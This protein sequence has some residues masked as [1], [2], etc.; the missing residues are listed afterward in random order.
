MSQRPALPKGTRDFNAEQVVKRQ[1][2]RDTIVE[3]YE[4]F[5]FE[6]LETPSMELLST[7]TGKYGVEGDQLLFRILKSGDFL[8]GVK[9]EALAKK[10]ARAM[11]PE[12][13][14]KGLRY[15]LTVPFARY[16]VMNQHNLTMPFRRYQVQPVW[17]ADRPQKGR[18]Q[19]F[20][21]CDAD[22]IGS[23]TMLSE[24]EFIQIYDEVFRRLGIKARL[25]INNRKILNGVA[26]LIKA[27]E[28]FGPICVAMDKLDKIGPEG[29]REELLRFGL[30]ASQVDQLQDLL[31]IEGSNMMR[32]NELADRFAGG[33]IDPKGIE[34]MW[35]I[36][37][38]ASQLGIEHLDIR[39]D[40]SLARGLS[41]Y[42]GTIFE[43]VAT[44]HQIG[45]LSGGGRYDDLTGIFGLPD[46]SG[47]GI[48]FGIERLYDV[49]EEQG[50]PVDFSRRGTRVVF[51][52]FEASCVPRAMECLR[53]VRAAGINAELH[54]DL[55]AK[56]G[57]KIKYADKKGIPFAAIIGPDELESGLVKLKVLSSGDQ[58]SL[59]LAAL[60]GRLA[61]D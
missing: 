29:V 18:Y 12:I 41:Y 43:V 6:P 49:L 53:A 7:L 34:E 8:K 33:W 36:L 4:R 16:V 38:Y 26:S 15:D 61:Q 25:R 32:L 11:L 42:T 3:V 52:P 37:S 58:E 14:E 28:F 30:D 55:E 13:A 5:G 31:A 27:H 50:W 51:F 54:P 44:E 10:D 59:E 2:L 1:F 17:R 47:V 40:L 20:W 56:M 22:V 39:F 46:V 60:I 45:S 19:E 48:S 24:V 21:Q 9:P 35:E 23:D 57:K